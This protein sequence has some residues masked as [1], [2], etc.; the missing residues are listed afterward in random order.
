MEA[1]DSNVLIMSFILTMVVFFLNTML[2][3]GKVM[4]MTSMLISIGIL[5]LQMSIFSNWIEPRQYYPIINQI[6]YALYYV[7]IAG[8]LVNRALRAV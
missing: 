4:F 1:I 6:S 3:S 7:L 2:K 8:L 5:I